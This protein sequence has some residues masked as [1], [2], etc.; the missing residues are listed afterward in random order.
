VVFGLMPNQVLN[1]DTDMIFGRCG[2]YA[3]PWSAY[4]RTISLKCQRVRLRAEERLLEARPFRIDRS[5]DEARTEYA[6]G[7]FGENAIIGALPPARGSGEATGLDGLSE[8]ISGQGALHERTQIL[9]HSLK[10]LL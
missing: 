2:R 10:L 9:P 1:F 4:P 8:A 3:C 5:P 7:H 6:L